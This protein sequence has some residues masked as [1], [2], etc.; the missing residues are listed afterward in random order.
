[1]PEAISLTCSQICFIE[2]VEV[3]GDPWAIEIVIKI[4]DSQGKPILDFR[5]LPN[6]VVHNLNN[7]GNQIFIECGTSYISPI[8]YAVS[9]WD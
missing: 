5:I 1:M 3:V 7:E 6:D 9:I 8:G 4:N 2:Q